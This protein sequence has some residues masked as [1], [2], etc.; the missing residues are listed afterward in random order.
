MWRDIVVRGM[1]VHMDVH[2]IK[3]A[4]AIEVYIRVW[5]ARFR[6]AGREDKCQAYLAKGGGAALAQTTSPQAKE[7]EGGRGGER[8]GVGGGVNG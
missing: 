3:F 7:G 8:N 6:T 2:P 1:G 4:E 5:G